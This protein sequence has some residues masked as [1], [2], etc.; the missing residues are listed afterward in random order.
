MYLEVFP[1]VPQ[2]HIYLEVHTLCIEYP[3]YLT[4]YP[5]IPQGIYLSISGYTPLGNQWWGTSS[6]G[7]GPWDSLFIIFSIGKCGIKG[8]EVFIFFSSVSSEK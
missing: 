4:V 5:Y 6:F 3:I 2:Y 1:C 8:A 7:K